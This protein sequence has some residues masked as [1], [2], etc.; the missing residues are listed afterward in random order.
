MVET[1]HKYESL[2]KATAHRFGIA[3]AGALA[4]ALGIGVNAA[5]F[6]VGR[7]R[8]TTDVFPDPLCLLVRSDS[9]PQTDDAAMTIDAEC[10]H[11]HTV[12]VGTDENALPC[13]LLLARSGNP[14]FE[15]KGYALLLGDYHVTL[16][17]YSRRASVS[18]AL[19]SSACE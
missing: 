14:A 12:S 15:L 13:A 16:D 1:L 9:R 8:Q 5:I 2:L 17:L 7:L 3:L 18:H 19:R 4:L 11:D 6:N 10:G